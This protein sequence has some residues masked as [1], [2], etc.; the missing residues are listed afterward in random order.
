MI[1]IAS[2][3]SFFTM[4]AFQADY[5]WKTSIYKRRSTMKQVFIIGT[6]TLML[7]LVFGQAVCAGNPTFWPAREDIHPGLNFQCFAPGDFNSDGKMDIVEYSYPRDAIGDRISILYNEGNNTY[8]QAVISSQLTDKLY[9]SDFNGDGQVDFMAIDYGW[10]DVFHGYVD[11]GNFVIYTN[12]GN[13][14]FVEGQVFKD[15]HIFMDYE[16]TDLNR[17]GIK[18]I[19]FI[20]PRL[21]PGIL[22]SWL[23]QSNGTYSRQTEIELVTWPTD[24]SCGDFN[25]DSYPDVAVNYYDREN[26]S[27]FLND[28]TGQL[29]QA[30]SVSIG[31]YVGNIRACDINNDQVDDLII[32][33]C[34]HDPDVMKTNILQ[35]NGDATFTLKQSLVHDQCGT[36]I[37]TED[38]NGDGFQDVAVSILSEVIRIFENDGTGIFSKSGD[39]GIPAYGG[40]AVEDLTTVDFNGDYR[41]DIIA[42]HADISIL[43]NQGNGTFPEAMTYDANEMTYGIEKADINSDGHMDLVYG[44]DR[45]VTVRL[46]DSLGNFSTAVECSLIAA[47]TDVTIGDF[48]GDSRLDIAAAQST[49]N[50]VAVFINNVDGTFTFYD[51]IPVQSRPDQIHIGFFNSDTHLDLA[52]INPGIDSISLLFNDGSGSFT[53]GDPIPADYSDD[54]YLFGFCVGDFDGNG[55][56][57]LAV[58]EEDLMIFYNQGDGTFQPPSFF[59]TD[60]VN[61]SFADPVTEDINADGNPDLLVAS[62]V[63]YFADGGGGVYIFLNNGF[64]VFESRTLHENVFGGD[65]LTAADLNNDTLKDVVILCKDANHLSVMWQSA[66]GTFNEGTHRYGLLGSPFD[67]VSHDFNGDGYPDVAASNPTSEKIS[68]LF[69]ATSNI[70]TCGNTGVDVAMPAHH[71]TPGSPCG[72]VVTVCNPSEHAMTGYPLFVIME[73]FGYYF[74]AP[75]FTEDIDSYLPQ[76]PAIPPGETRITVLPEFTWPEGTGYATGLFMYAALT[77]PDVSQVEGELGIWEFGWSE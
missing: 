47:A 24:L 66:D 72:C 41:P 1:R 61:S 27:L 11:P 5:V 76:Y 19:V 62:Q 44:H 3:H 17:D 13:G 6:V 45:G 10:Y 64:G 42:G 28:S 48:N 18:D 52:V 55:F 69:N 8:S 37:L 77:T 9:S 68:I 22:V 75:G 58:T 73:A 2:N 40:H 53:V 60:G 71:F 31:F 65:R 29:N 14:T 21:G 26:C 36:G 49:A 39:Y 54:H 70:P 50:A 67:L 15:T 59:E 63:G 56:D 57:D 25:G 51:S 43:L 38:F 12:Q 30:L 16:I 74:F 7:G 4:N 20:L 23:G 35:N 33:F 34:D 32:N 46:G